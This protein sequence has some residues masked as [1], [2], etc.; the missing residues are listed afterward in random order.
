[1]LTPEDVE[2]LTNGFRTVSV[3]NPG[4]C[5]FKDHYELLLRDAEEP[6]ETKRNRLYSP[7]Y[8]NFDNG[9]PRVVVDEYRT[10]Q[11]RQEDPTGFYSKEEERDRSTTISHIR[12]ATSKDGEK[13]DWVSNEPAFPFSNVWEEFGME[14]PRIVQMGDSFIVSY[15]GYSRYGAVTLFRRTEDFETFSEPW[16]VTE[17]DGK[18]TFPFPEKIDGRYCMLTRPTGHTGIQYIGYSFS[19]D[20]VY[21]GEPGILIETREKMFDENGIGGGAPPLRTKDGWLEIYHGNKPNKNL[22]GYTD[23]GV[24][25][26]DNGNGGFKV[27]ARSN[28]S[29]FKGPNHT[30]IKDDTLLQGVFFASGACL[31]DDDL[32]VF[33]GHDDQNTV[34][35][36]TPLNRV[37]RSMNNMFD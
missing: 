12:R 28:H 25:F 18:D 19:S 32:R 4:A 5:W 14:D 24:L 17:P 29:L 33:G 7:R 35:L 2:P 10:D 6:I 22:K 26:D 27:K 37:M 21:W 36:V 30:S 20:L 8:K 3:F 23:G 31:E 16:R 15:V 1:M 9:V 34:S 11:C 13:I